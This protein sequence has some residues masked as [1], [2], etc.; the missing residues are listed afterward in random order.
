MTGQ[1]G[2]DA[3]RRAEAEQYRPAGPPKLPRGIADENF[4]FD[5]RSPLRQQLDELTAKIVHDQAAAF[6][7]VARQA[8][9]GWYICLHTVEMLTHPETDWLDTDT[10]KFSVR[11]KFHL[12][13]P[14]EPCTK[15][16]G[17]R[18]L[19]GPR[20]VEPVDPDQP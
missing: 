10:L 15:G 6:E 13:E 2:P 18:T 20:P 14:G 4:N 19:F 11:Q 3:M 8:P 9:P 7:A 1:L 12:L 5:D 17:G 16:S